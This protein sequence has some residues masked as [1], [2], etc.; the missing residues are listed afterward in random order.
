MEGRHQAGC[1]SRLRPRTQLAKA[2]LV[3]V[4]ERTPLDRVGDVDLDLL[5]DEAIP[6]IAGIL[7]D[8]GADPH[9]GTTCPESE[10]PSRQ[11][12]RARAPAARRPGVGRDPSRPRGPAVGL[13]G[14]LGR[15]APCAGPA[16][17][18]A[19][20]AAGRDLRLGPG[21]LPRAWIRRAVP[22]SRRRPPIRPP[23]PAATTSTSWL[24]VLLAE[25]RRYGHPFA[26]ALPRSR[27]SSRSTRRTVAS[28]ATGHADRVATMIRS[29]IRIVDRA[30]RGTTTSSGCSRRTST[31]GRLR[32]MADRLVRVVDASQSTD[33]PRIAIRAASRP[34]PSTGTTRGRS[35]SRLA[36][37]KRGREWRLRRA[38]SRDRPG[39]PRD[40]PPGR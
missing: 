18:P 29:Q 16:T 31:P 40:S 5:A 25:Y 6:L 34:V 24:D 39:L 13:I 20:L 12:A 9:G 3:A 26:L 10:H 32:S 2:W 11:R 4:I 22:S 1:R 27:A 7:R 33:R 35:A 19:P 14:S 30:F 15:D 23:C 37:A 21:A 8:R 36:A 28:R 38:R 17:S